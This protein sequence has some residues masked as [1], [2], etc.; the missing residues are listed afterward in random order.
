MTNQG[1]QTIT[2]EIYILMYLLSAFARRAS[3]LNQRYIQ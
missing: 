1:V 3:L 2:D